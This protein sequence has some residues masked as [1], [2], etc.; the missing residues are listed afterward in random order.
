[1][2]EGWR[3]VSRTLAAYA[4]AH[5]RAARRWSVLLRTKGAGIGSRPFRLRDEAEALAVALAERE[6]GI[7]REAGSVAEVAARR[8]LGIEG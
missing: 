5:D 2:R 3:A 7:P 8:S 6:T 4:R 1:V